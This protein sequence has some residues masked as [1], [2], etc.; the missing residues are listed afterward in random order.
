[1]YHSEGDKIKLVLISNLIFFAHVIW[2]SFTDMKAI[3]VL[4]ECVSIKRRETKLRD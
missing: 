3:A 1:M 4:R 2:E